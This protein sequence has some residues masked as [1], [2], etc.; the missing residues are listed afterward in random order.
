MSQDNSTISTTVRLRLP[1][2][3]LTVIEEWAAAHDV[4]RSTALQQLAL[5]GLAWNDAPAVSVS[6]KPRQQPQLAA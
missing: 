4:P 5:R 3:L 1:R 2:Q 6:L